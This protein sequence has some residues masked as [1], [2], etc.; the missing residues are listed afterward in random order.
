MTKLIAFEGIDGAGKSSQIARLAPWIEKHYGPVVTT[1]EPTNGPYGSQI[2]QAKTRLLPALERN[3]FLLDRKEHAENFIRPNIKSGKFVIT[4]RYF[5]SSVAYQGSRRDAFGF[6]PA[7]EDFIRLQEEIFA[8]NCNIAPIPDILVFI[9]IA[10]EA[11]LRRIDTGRSARDPFETLQT[12]TTVAGVFRRIVPHHPHHV[13]VD[14]SACADVI[15]REI[16]AKI[17]VLLKESAI[18]DERLPV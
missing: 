15:A 3:L 8:E 6:E 18:K 14:G 2:R 1:A 11:A 7:S 10:P 9:D 4:D 17:D 13:I 16:T 12:L 5:Y